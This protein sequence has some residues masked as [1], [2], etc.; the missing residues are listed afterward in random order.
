MREYKIIREAMN[1]V[2][3]AENEMVSIKEIHLRSVTPI[4]FKVPFYDATMGPF[5]YYTPCFLK[6][7]DDED[8]SG[9][10][11]FPGSCLYKCIIKWSYSKE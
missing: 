10:C 5:A 9:E 6:I 4:K 1:S 2:N 3:I 7:T 11:E 8:Y